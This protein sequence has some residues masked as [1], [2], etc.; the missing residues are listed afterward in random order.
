MQHLT[1]EELVL[2]HYHD[3]ASPASAEQ[4]LS[5]CDGCRREYIAIRGVLAMVDDMPVPEREE[6]YGEQVWT[7]LRWRLG[8]RRRMRV[9][10]SVAAVAAVLAIAFFAG[11]WWHAR[12]SPGKPSSVQAANREQGVAV[13]QAQQ[14]AQH[15]R[16]RILFV[17]VTDHLDSSERMLTDLANADPKRD[18]DMST[19]RKRAGELV[20][21][22]RIYRQTAT[23]RG[24]ERLA[25]LLTELEPVLLELAHAD[26]KLSPEDLATLQKRIESKGLLFKVRAASAQTKGMNS[27]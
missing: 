4:H 21:S 19:E 26:E 18:L 3:D 14:A 12:S 16:D 11:V 8:S 10:E 15:S 20:V 17:V 22:N 9:W 24:D 5:T 1:E 6:A 23:R 27:L 7:R 13:A 25:A 2:H